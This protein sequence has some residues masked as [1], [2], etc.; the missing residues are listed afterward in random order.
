MIDFFY[1]ICRQILSHVWTISGRR[2]ICK[3]ISCIIFERGYSFSVAARLA[4]RLPARAG[5]RD[6]SA[7]LSLHV[8]IYET[9]MDTEKSWRLDN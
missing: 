6:V 3:E 7:A 2:L 8:R 9:E 5:K 4:R 1:I